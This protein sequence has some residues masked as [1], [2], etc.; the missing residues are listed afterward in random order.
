LTPEGIRHKHWAPGSAVPSMAQQVGE[1]YR[2]S[3]Y[4]NICRQ[5]YSGCDY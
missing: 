3:L 1:S 2:V 5:T 4:E